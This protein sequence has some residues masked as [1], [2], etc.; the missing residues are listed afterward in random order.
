MMTDRNTTKPDVISAGCG[1]TISHIS[2][3]NLQKLYRRQITFVIDVGQSYSDL[4]AE[5]VT[6]RGTRQVK[7]KVKAYWCHRERW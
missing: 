3:K 2:T 7:K 4:L 1:S 5:S 6:I